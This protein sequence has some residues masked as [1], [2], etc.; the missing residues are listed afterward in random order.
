MNATGIIAEYNPF[1][2]GHLNQI[3]ITES[4]FPNDPVICVMSGS[5]VQ[6]GEPAIFN[7]YARTEAALKC[8]AAMVIELPFAFAS[9]SAEYFASYA[10]GIL[11]ASGIADKICFGSECGN[12]DLL[13]KTAEILAFE[14][15][16]YRGLLRK[17][18]ALGLSY[19]RARQ[20][21]VSAILPESADI[22]AEPNNILGI[23]YIKAI[24]TQSAKLAPYTIK[25][26]GEG[27]HSLDYSTNLSSA[28]AIRAAIKGGCFSSTLNA[29]PEQIADI[30]KKQIENNMTFD[31]DTYSPY[32][33]Y[34]ISTMTAYE[35]A[36]IAGVEEGLENAIIKAC[37]KHRL[38]SE[39]LSELKSKRYTYTKLSRVLLHIILGL[40]KN[41]FNEY[42]TNKPHYIRVLGFRKEYE[43]LLAQMEKSA[44]APLIINLKNSTQKLSPTGA[45]LLAGEI[46]ATD[47]YNLAAPQPMAKNAEYSQPLVII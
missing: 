5:F 45:K 44:K 28:T 47:I 27:Y 7:K 26:L 20:E 12:I 22:L 15:M 43:Y 18:L 23:E 8:G 24:L 14:S 10:I 6:R 25:R 42:L 41:D 32:L 38:I 46:A 3:K 40:T 37:G 9:S 2:N 29:V 31:F 17:N 19:P 30:Y 1:H 36:G 33:H 35:L 11:E 34:R 4:M 21:A 13:K 39:I 16:E